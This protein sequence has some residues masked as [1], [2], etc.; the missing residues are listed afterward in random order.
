M[1]TALAGTMAALQQHAPEPLRTPAEWEQAWIQQVG[2]QALRLIAP[3]GEAA[4]FQPPVDGSSSPRPVEEL[5]P[6]NLGPR[7]A[8]KDSVRADA[9][10]WVY[11][12]LSAQWRAHMGVGQYAGIRPGLAVALPSQDGT[13]GS[14]IRTLMAAYLA[15]QP[16]VAGTTAKATRAADHLLWLRP[17]TSATRPLPVDQVPY[18][19]VDARP[20][21]LHLNGG[22][23]EGRAYAV[24]GRRIHDQA[25]LEDPHVPLTT[26]D[27]TVTDPL[28]GP[29]GRGC[30]YR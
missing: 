22:Q 2:P 15:H 14:E 30:R 17:W 7:H 11:G 5:G 23:I 8:V 1:V 19:A 12:L 29:G 24:S 27:T 18:P 21:R 25:L 10:Q 26:L 20:V 4:F 9:E 6:P 13:I 3:P 28:A 16:I